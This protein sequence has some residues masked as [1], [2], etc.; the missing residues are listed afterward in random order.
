[1][2]D[3][4]VVEVLLGDGLLDDLLQDLLAEL[5]GGDVRAV[6]SGHDDG[7]DADRDHGTVV[8]LVLDGD[9]GLGVRAEPRQTAV[10][11]G[12]RHR[13]VELV[14]KE[15]GQG[16]ELRGLVGGVAEHNTLVTSAQ[17]LEGL[18]VVKALR[19]VG[20]LLLDG[21]EEIEGLVVETLLR[22]VVTNVLD[23][24]ADDLL[25]VE[26]GV[27]GDLTEDHDHTGLG[28]RLA[29]NLGETVL[30]QAGV[31]NGIGDLVR[32]LVGVALADRL[33]L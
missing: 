29:G 11:A 5:L 12:G 19:D 14:G 9:L 24:L 18:L 2:V 33:G 3:G 13:G 23:S 21:D 7:V 16:E 10:T 1:M 8:V 26:L 20:R 25:V 32:N 17:L 6:L 15:E 4:L 31:E 27:G 22:V 28:G 30:R